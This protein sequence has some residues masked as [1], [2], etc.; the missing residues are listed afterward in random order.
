MRKTGGIS[1][2]Y[3]SGVG[4]AQVGATGMTRAMAL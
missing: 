1:K 4:P 3:G 2:I